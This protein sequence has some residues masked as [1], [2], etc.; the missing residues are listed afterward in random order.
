VSLNRTTYLGGPFVRRFVRYLTQVITGTT[1]INFTVGFTTRKLWRGFQNEFP[2]Y[3]D[4]RSSGSSLHVVR[5]ETLE[6]LFQMYW[7]KNRDY[8]ENKLAL[9]AVCAAIKIAIDGEDGPSQRK[10]AEDASHEVMKWGFGEGR[11][12]YKA[13]MEWARRQGEELPSVLRV[14]REALS[15][16]NPDIGAF[17]TGADSRTCMPKMNAGWTKYYA[18]ALPRHIIYDGRVG[19]ALGFLVRRYLESLPLQVQPTAVPGELG[20]LW[21]SGDG[22]GKLR[23]PSAGRYK[24]DKLSHA[25]KE[26]KTWA[27]INIQANWILS[28]A[29]EKAKATW[30]SGPEGLRKLEAALFMLGYDLS[31]ADG[32]E[33]NRGDEE[34]PPQA[35]TTSIRGM[36][37]L[38]KVVDANFRAALKAARIAAGLN[39]S[40]LARR[41][42]IS[43]VMPARYEDGEH[44]NAAL[45]SQETWEKLNAALFPRERVTALEVNGS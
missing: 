45:P 12:P 21:A 22:E 17:G 1:P 37:Q 42:G 8:G 2:G 27:R 38:P 4:T 14:G 30:C 39:Y 24:F 36:S 20:F 10:L 13:N 29:C 11:R 43:V 40:E 7:W 15:G 26:S 31:L 5:A 18:L 41:A 44:S 35:E 32:A 33:N 6:Q 25:P 34:F 3:L 19:A 23:D 9:D 28:E 16:D